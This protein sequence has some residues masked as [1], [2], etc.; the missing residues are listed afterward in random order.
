MTTLEFIK[1]C[2]MTT[3][4]NLEKAK[5]RTGVTQKEIDALTE[6]KG[7]YEKILKMLKKGE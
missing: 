6:K 4:I 5:K 1:K 3:D 2:L 7:H